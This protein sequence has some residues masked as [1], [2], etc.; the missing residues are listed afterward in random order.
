MN[1]SKVRDNRN[2]P[3]R[4]E[5]KFE[6]LRNLISATRKIPFA[7]FGKSRPLILSERKFSSLIDDK[8]RAEENRYI[9]QEEEKQKAK[10][11]ESFEKLLAEESSNE[12][13]AEILGL[14]GTNLSLFISN[15]FMI[16][17]MM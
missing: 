14:L 12:K 6:M 15:Q 9:R 13:K 11:R 5:K 4:S 1:L 8:K 3:P 16:T 10:L 2:S 17:M 7:K